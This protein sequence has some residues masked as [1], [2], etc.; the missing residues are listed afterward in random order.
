MRLSWEE[1]TANAVLFVRRQRQHPSDS[2]FL[3]EF[4][5]IFGDVPASGQFAYRLAGGKTID[6]LQPGLLAAASVPAGGSLTE[7]AAALA[8][9]AASLPEELRPKWVLA[10][11]AK[12]V[13]LL[14]EKS[15]GTH[16]FPL[17]SLPKQVR[18]FADIAGY[19]AVRNQAQ[20]TERDTQA[21][22]QMQHLHDILKDCGYTGHALEVYLVRLLFCLF[23]EDIG[24]FQERRFSALLQDTDAAN[25]SQGLADLF[26]ALGQASA[27]DDTLAAAS[28]IGGGLF[29]EALPVYPLS[30]AF[31][32]SLC[33][34][35]AFDWQEISPVLFGA[36]FQGV[37][38]TVARRSGG[39]HYTSEE[40]IF[41]LINPLFLDALWEEFDR[42][43]SDAE[44]L[45]LFHQKLGSLTFLDPACGCGNFLI[46]TY[47]ELRR[48]ELAVLNMLVGS[49]QLMLDITPLRKVH[50]DQ[51]FGI[52]L[53]GFPCLIARVGMWLTD[54]Q[55]NRL[56]A[57]RFGMYTQH[58][59]QLYADTI[60][61]G[62]ALE[63]DWDA[64]IPREKL[65]YILGN[66]P[67]V[68][69]MMMTR[70]QKQEMQKTFHMHKGIGE[71]DYV[72]AWYQRAAEYMQGTEI[73]AAFVST[74]SIT[75]GQQAVLLWQPLLTDMGLHII[76]ARRTFVWEADHADRSAVHCVIIGF[77]YADRTPKYIFDNTQRIEA[78]QINAYLMDAP[79]VFVTA[80]PT[81]CAAAPAMYFGS[82][83]RDGGN[84]I[85]TEADCAALRAETP[86]ADKWIR[87]Y[88]GAYELIN[89]KPRWCLWLKDAL[90]H[91]LAQSPTVQARLKAVR[92][93]R[94]KSVAAA[95]RRYA[96]TPSLFCQDAQ[97]DTAYL[98]LPRVSSQRRF[99]LPMAFAEKDWIA[100]DSLLL[101]PGAD[102]YTF[103][104]L[105]SAAHMAWMRA[106]CGR[107][108]SD[109]RYSKDIVYNNFPWPEVGA[110]EKQA[111][112]EAAQAVL[113]ARAAYPN[114]S[115]ADLYDPAAMPPAL[116]AAHAELDR[117]VE[118]A[119]HAKWPSEDA[120]VRDLLAHYQAMTSS[121][122]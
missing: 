91:E 120:C 74:N 76:F 83:P 55:M 42:V 96:E 44:A 30:E 121:E 12:G 97:P 65:S 41:R 107:L 23:A 100:G 78:Q 20:Q 115:L 9:Q 104:I 17:R 77:S 22:A 61:Q 89:Q 49:R 34:A 46:L 33:T 79:P 15:G 6:Y 109:Y 43:K 64:V 19:A 37:T 119:Y 18:L 82:M 36:M 51:F 111:I 102:L 86:A 4:L 85:L 38:D 88:L 60:V 67:F 75:Q 58:L 101:I 84:L 5:A 50:A 47:R 93:F 70:T 1:I 56:A 106:V 14:S 57:A 54:I 32:Q 87:P 122:I 105:T 26:A 21:A 45:A 62:N 116:Q 94:A 48:L 59:P 118:A 99:Y 69:G 52:E 3:K 40:N 16:T 28:Q 71:L 25:L 95:T 110:A 80:R 24:I 2:L 117:L 66:P 53:S 72:C 103:G 114:R 81:P 7:T 8:G 112:A 31:R 10:C 68:G 39:V 29:Q 13:C 63:T 90:E 113:T 27:A 92:D 11:S 73:A 35:C 108:K 98:A